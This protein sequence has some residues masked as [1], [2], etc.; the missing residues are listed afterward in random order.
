M[1]TILIKKDAKNEICADIVRSK[2]FRI[3]GKYCN[4]YFDKKFFVGDFAKYD[5]YR[6]LET[7]KIISVTEKTV[8]ISTKN[9]TNKFVK[10]HNFAYRNYKSE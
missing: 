2:Y 5:A 8:L 4:H 10:I 7:G 9:G 6:W 3:Y 1:I